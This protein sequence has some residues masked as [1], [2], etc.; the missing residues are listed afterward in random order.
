MSSFEKLECLSFVGETKGSADLDA[1]GA[2]AEELTP[3]LDEVQ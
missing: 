3:L 2:V 1:F